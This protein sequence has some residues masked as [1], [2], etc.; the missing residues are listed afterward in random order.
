MSTSSLSG[1]VRKVATKHP[2][3]EL[4][5]IKGKEFMLGLSDKGQ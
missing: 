2:M 1:F 4:R 3:I 5:K